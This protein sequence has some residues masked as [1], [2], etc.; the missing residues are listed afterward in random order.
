ML[1]SMHRK[2]KQ[3]SEFDRASLSGHFVN[4]DFNLPNGRHNNNAIF[5]DTNCH[6]RCIKFIFVFGT[7][8]LWCDNSHSSHL[9]VFIWYAICFFYWLSDRAKIL[10]EHQQKIRWIQILK[11]RHIGSHRTIDNFIIGSSDAT[12]YHT[13]YVSNLCGLWIRP[14][15]RVSNHD[16]IWRIGC[17]TAVIKVTQRDTNY[18]IWSSS[19]RV[20]APFSNVILLFL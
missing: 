19:S 14:I 6:S 3:K 1:R 16:F 9:Q 17:R 12:V 10:F 5:D 8:L 13:L 4:I 20:C 18:C 7:F 11:C 2:Q 15:D